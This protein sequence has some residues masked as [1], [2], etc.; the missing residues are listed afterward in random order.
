MPVTPLREAVIVVVPELTLLA[1]PCE[2]ITATF[3][4]E[5]VHVA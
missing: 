1:N 4:F 2:L 5:D 3:T